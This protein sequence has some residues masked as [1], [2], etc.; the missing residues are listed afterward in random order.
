MYKEIEYVQ[1]AIEFLTGWCGLSQSSLQAQHQRRR[2]NGMCPR[3]EACRKSGP[4]S[5]VPH[6]CAARNL[7][8]SVNFLL[9]TMKAQLA[10]SLQHN[11]ITHILRSIMHAVKFLFSL[12]WKGWYTPVLTVAKA[13]INPILSTTTQM[14]PAYVA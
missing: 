11:P 8:L 13:R 1:T 9:L 14:P 7:N 12:S 2:T 10:S 6:Q 3:P 5:P 4:Q